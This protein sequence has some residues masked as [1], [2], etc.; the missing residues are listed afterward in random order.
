MSRIHND[1]LDMMRAF[2]ASASSQDVHH[3]CIQAWNCWVKGA[4]LG[5]LKKYAGEKLKALAP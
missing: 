2:V 3:W 4:D 1:E 5:N